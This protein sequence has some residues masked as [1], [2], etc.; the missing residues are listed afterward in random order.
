MFH[1]RPLGWVSAIQSQL[2]AHVRGRL[3]PMLAKQAD[4]H[5]QE[6]SSKFQKA[7]KLFRDAVWASRKGV[8]ALKGSCHLR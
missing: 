7:N 2:P 5:H 8:E 3:Q 1:E 4:S 6:C